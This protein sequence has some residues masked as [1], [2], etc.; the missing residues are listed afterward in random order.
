MF[1]SHGSWWKE[2]LYT[3]W[4]I[5]LREVCTCLDRM[6][7]VK[8][9]FVHAVHAKVRMCSFYISLIC[10]GISFREN[11]REICYQIFFF[12]RYKVRVHV[13]TAWLLVKRSSVYVCCTLKLGKIGYRIHDKTAWLLVRRRFVYAVHAKVRK[14]FL[15]NTK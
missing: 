14:L 4:Y 6:V 15:V 8:R 11:L 1:R 9:R 10:N 12:K 3:L 7:T 13:Q 5:A 2:A